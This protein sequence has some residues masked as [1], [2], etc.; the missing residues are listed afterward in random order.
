MVCHCELHHL[1]SDMHLVSFEFV[2]GN[3]Q[4][5]FSGAIT[6]PYLSINYVTIKKKGKFHLYLSK[7]LYSCGGHLSTSLE[8]NFRNFI[9]MTLLPLKNPFEPP[10]EG[11]LY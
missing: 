9:F 5:D 11:F 3:T 4:G 8:N 10:E 7:A 1:I 6:P 2:E